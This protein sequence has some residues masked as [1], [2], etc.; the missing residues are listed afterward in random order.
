VAA[1]TPS[2]DSRDVL[3]GVAVPMGATTLLA[4]Y[5][6]KDDRSVLDRDANQ[7]AIGATYAVSK[8]TDFYA[9][10]AKIQN[11]NGAGYTTGNASAAGRGD[12]AVNVGIRH[13]F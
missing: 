4:S 7:I 1:S 8:R 6:H 11:R 9:S 2:N 12:R 10:L 13:A 3:V 5:V